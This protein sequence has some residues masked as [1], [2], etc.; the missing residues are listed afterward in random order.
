MENYKFKSELVRSVL[1]T[2]VTEISHVKREE[3]SAILN[4]VK[5]ASK[6]AGYIEM[7]VISRIKDDLGWTQESIAM[8]LSQI[9]K[10]ISALKWRLSQ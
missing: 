2:G 3:V 8:R 7:F 1:P 4:D 10:D 9:Q 5:N 6:T